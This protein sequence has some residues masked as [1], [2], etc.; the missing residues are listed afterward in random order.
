MLV[1]D[2]ISTTQPATFLDVAAGPGILTSVIL[3]C[4]EQENRQV[5]MGSQFFVTDYAEGMV[6]TAKKC[7]ETIE[8]AKFGLSDLQCYCMDA[9]HPELPPSASKLTHVGCMFGIMFFPDRKA[10]L[11]RLHELMIPGGKVIIGTWF[12]ADFL[13]LSYEFAASLCSTEEDF[14]EMPATC[15]PLPCFNPEETKQE[16]IETG[17]HHIEIEQYSHLFLL[18]NNEELFNVL[19][20]NPVVINKYPKIKNMHKSELHEK[21]LL[22]LNSDHENGKKWLREDG[23]IVALEFTGNIIIGLA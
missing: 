19:V 2:F 3:K 11:Q 13:V 12:H 18:P 16:L 7:F 21:W 5:P 20:M 22:F 15:D 6:E 9:C 1:N 17:F 10:A 14:Q 23:K 4:L 8:L